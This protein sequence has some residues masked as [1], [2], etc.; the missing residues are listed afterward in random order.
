MRYQCSGCGSDNIVESFCN[1]C[2]E[3]IDK[4]HECII[5][6]LEMRIE[7][8]RAALKKCCCCIIASD[9]SQNYKCK[10]CRALA[11]DDKSD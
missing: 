5:K 11:E 6:K 1:E 2:S 10:P 7:K 4:E 3:D 9:K 8:L